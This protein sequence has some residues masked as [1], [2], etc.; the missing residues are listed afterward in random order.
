MFL[1][2]ERNVVVDGDDDWYTF[3]TY[4]PIGV[5]STKEDAEKY[6]ASIEAEYDAALAAHKQGISDSNKAWKNANP[7]PADTV[8]ASAPKWGLMKNADITPEMRAER[9]R[10]KEQNDQIRRENSRVFAL[11]VSEFTVAEM[12]YLAKNKPPKERHLVYQEIEQ[13]KVAT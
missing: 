8:F 2:L 3:E 4:D 9:Q 5:V 12:E 1:V 13:L 10:I 11:W 6:I 7:R